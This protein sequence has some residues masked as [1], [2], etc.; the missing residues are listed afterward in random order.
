MDLDR[1]VLEADQSLTL[2]IHYTESGLK[3]TEVT[4]GHV[5]VMKPKYNSSRHA[6]IFL[7]FL[8]CHFPASWT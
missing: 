4:K 6:E 7:P 2:G 3:W 5:G 8:A 1:F